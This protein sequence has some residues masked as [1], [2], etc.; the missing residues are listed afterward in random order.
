MQVFNYEGPPQVSPDERTGLFTR[1]IKIDARYDHE[2][3]SYEKLDNPI[4]AACGEDWL[5]PYGCS[6]IRA[7]WLLG[8]EETARRGAEA[9]NERLTSALSRVATAG[10]W[11]RVENMRAIGM[12]FLVAD[13][14]LEAGG[15]HVIDEALAK[16]RRDIKFWY[17]EH[18]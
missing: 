1:H 16:V 6:A 12:D 5:A 15:I 2:T 4:C 11:R 8:H 18:K 10:H 13:F 3:D 7:L 9:T 17:D 14:A